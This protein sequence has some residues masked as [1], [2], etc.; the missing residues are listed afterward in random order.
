MQ[1][2]I[3]DSDIAEEAPIEPVAQPKKA[4]GSRLR[5][6]TGRT[7]YSENSRLEKLKTL[8]DG[9][10]CDLSALKEMRLDSTSLRGNIECLI[11]S[12]EIPVGAIGPLTI[13]GSEGSSEIFAPLATS[14]G[15]LVSSINRGCRAL[16]MSGGV[17]AQFIKQRM[18]RAPYFD[19]GTIKNCRRLQKWIQHNVGVI[20]KKVREHSNYATL[21]HLDFQIVPPALHVRFIYETGDASG[22]NMTTVC[23]WSVCQWILEEVEKEHPDLIQ[24]FVI[25]GNLSADKKVANS[26]VLVGRGCQVIVEAHIPK[27]VY[28]RVFQIDPEEMIHRY[29]QARSSGLFTGMS[30]FNVNASNV[31]AGIFT[32]TGQDIACVHESSQAQLHM[33][34]RG[35]GIY[36]SLILP[37][38]VIGTVGGGVGLA[39]QKQ[40]LGMMGCYGPSSVRKFAEA[41]ASFT[42]ALELS[43]I[44]ALA[45]GQFATAHESLGR[46]KS[47]NWL[48]KKELQSPTFFNHLLRQNNLHNPIVEV[49]ERE[50]ETK[51][52]SLVMDLT[53]QISQRL[54]GLWRYSLSYA[55]GQQEEVFIKSKV[56]DRELLLATEIMAGMNSPGLGELLKECRDDNL[57]NGTHIRE[58]ELAKM[59]STSL[60]QLMPAVKGTLI[61]QKRQIFMLALEHLSEMH[62]FDAVE[63]RSLWSTD[64]IRSAISA[65]SQVHAEFLGKTK[66]LQEAPWMFQIDLDR[67]FRLKELQRE[68][69]R[70]LA[71]D[72]PE[73][74]RDDD[75]QFHL[76]HLESLSAWWPH[77]GDK[78]LT[79]VHNDFNPRNIGFR[80][81]QCLP[82]DLVVYDW[83]LSTVGLPQKDL[84]E[85]L[86]FV[87]EE[88]TTDSEIL[89]MIYFHKVKIEHLS[90]REVSREVWLHDTR[91]SILE[92]ILFRLP[93]YAVAQTFRKVDFLKPTYLSARRI[94]QVIEKEI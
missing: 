63:Q 84:V 67:A 59:S 45:G 27:S 47:Q 69:A 79:L 55:D 1:E 33:E 40:L 46:N 36:A 60:Q 68:L 30:G 10:R 62:L 72:S 54:C 32:A 87:L 53:T 82:E 75:L 8:E 76:S 26:S 18:V 17:Q 57:F 93:I 29:I 15:A 6:L 80:S 9:L 86:S 51:G 13:H 83:E 71:C 23:T 12:V 19:C 58:I 44:A 35:D 89:Q 4:P 78:D 56:P 39:I 7:N 31:I 11:G 14:E 88:T 64:K 3:V 25:D 16:S 49:E 37:S 34:P 61:N 24:K 90:N 70:K 41:I 81:S 77:A 65:I 94:L 50:L 91:A 38:L 43:T 42:L 66:D 48:E 2:E 5:P 21:I 92:F 22:Q 20:R 28:R 73:W 74:F 52:E 85:F